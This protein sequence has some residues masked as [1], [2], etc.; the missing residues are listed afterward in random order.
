MSRGKQWMGQRLLK[1]VESSGLV[2]IHLV[3]Q[4]RRAPLL[5]C[6]AR[7]VTTLTRVNFEHHARTLE[8]NGNVTELTRRRVHDGDRQICRIV[9]LVLGI[10]CETS[11]HAGTWAFARCS[12]STGISAMRRSVNRASAPASASDWGIPYPDVRIDPE[13]RQNRVESEFD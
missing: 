7:F 2:G 10:E 9:D 3:A 13:K 12:A 11:A 4:R 6:L 5:S 1:V 8:Q